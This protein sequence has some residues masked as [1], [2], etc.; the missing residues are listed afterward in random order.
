[1]STKKRSLLK[2]LVLGDSGVGKTC[3]IRQFAQH[4]FSTQY[5]ATIGA[6]FLTKEFILDDRQVTMQI[7]DTAGLERFQSLGVAFYRGADAC[8]LV[9]DVTVPKSFYNLEGWKDEFLFQGAPQDPEH[10]PFL[11]IGN[12]TDLE[13]SRA[14]STKKAEGWC[15]SNGSMTHFETSAKDNT[16]VEQ[17]FFDVAR[18]AISR[19]I[20]EDDE[21]QHAVDIHT[22]VEPDKIRCCG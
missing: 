20:V 22:D 21:I 8:V 11:V 3:L 14:V 7:W 15:R 6:D 2:V 18:T 9:Y 12:K 4:K 19:E 5:K 10:F 17:A 1:M 13:D 16:N